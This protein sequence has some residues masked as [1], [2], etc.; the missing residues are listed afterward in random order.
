LA[1]PVKYRW[2]HIDPRGKWFLRS[3]HYYSFG[4]SLHAALQRFHGTDD[5]G[6][7]TTQETIASL[8]ENWISAGYASPEEAAEALAEGREI[9][10]QYFESAAVAASEIPPLFVEKQLSLDMG[11]FTLV[12]RLDRVD[13]LPDGTLE[14]IDYKSGGRFSE[15]ELLQDVAMSSYHLLLREHMPD[16]RILL[17]IVML[18]SGERITVEQSF[19]HLDQFAADVKAIGIEIL[20]REYHEIDPLPKT[21]CQRCDF[22]PLCERHEEFRESFQ[23][24]RQLHN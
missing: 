21:L 2:T 8:E 3:K 7:S 19:R 23:E 9:V 13:E 12:G 24:L 4:L 5:L 11:G 14:I 18:R 15:D 20:N 1:C 16:R 6:V 17:T 10:S 22:L